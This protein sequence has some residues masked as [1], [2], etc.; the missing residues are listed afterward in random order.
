M[1]DFPIPQIAQ[2]L[3]L[4]Q[5]Q[6]AAT[7]SLLDD[8]AAVN[9]SFVPQLWVN[10]LVDPT[11][12]NPEP[13]SYRRDGLT[14]PSPSPSNGVTNR[15]KAHIQGRAGSRGLYPGSARR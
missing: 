11:P 12:A 5:G 6:V 8:G 14:T 15:H 7:V 3:R 1:I 2:E 9:G 4:A 13:G 10:P